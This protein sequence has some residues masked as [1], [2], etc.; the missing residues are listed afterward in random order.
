VMFFSSSLQNLPLLE[1]PPLNIQ[2]G[3]TSQWPSDFYK[4]QTDWIYM[5][6]RY[7][8]CVTTVL[9]GLS[10][11]IINSPCWNQGSKFGFLELNSCSNLEAD[12]CPSSELSGCVSQN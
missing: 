6:I 12:K 2:D 9:L 3:V 7:T 8:V 11:S 1:L 10:S 4:L 5:V